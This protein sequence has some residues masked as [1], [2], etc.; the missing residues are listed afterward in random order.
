MQNIV[1]LRELRENVG[2]YAARVAR[3]ESFVVMRRSRPMFRIVPVDDEEGWETVV[4][5][6]K[7]PKYKGGIRAE[8]LLKTLD[9]IR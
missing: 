1:G 9:K 3:G 2:K 5:F 8:E 4:D 6:T 7:I